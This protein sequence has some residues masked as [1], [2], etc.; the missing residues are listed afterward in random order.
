M[1]NPTTIRRHE[2]PAVA[3]AAVLRTGTA[4]VQEG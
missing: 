3:A 2:R 1:T 4:A